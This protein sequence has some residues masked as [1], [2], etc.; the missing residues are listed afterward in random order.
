MP[1]GPEVSRVINDEAHARDCE[2]T[3]RGP[4]TSKIHCSLHPDI[5]NAPSGCQASECVGLGPDGI[6]LPKRGTPSPR[7][8]PGL[9]PVVSDRGLACSESI[10]KRSA[11]SLTNGF[12]LPDKSQRSLV[13]RQLGY[14]NRPTASHSI[15]S[16]S[17]S[18]NESK[19]LISFWQD[20]NWGEI[21]KQLS[22]TKRIY[23][24][25]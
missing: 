7:G 15:A 22:S 23:K 9:E 3:T 5:G 13:S 18:A 25:D 24:P 21:D 12:A 19:Q 6:A 10:L 20:P 4:R 2:G 14:M 11:A 17:I 1:W 16:H 8:D